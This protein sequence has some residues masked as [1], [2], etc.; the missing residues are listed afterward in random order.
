MTVQVKYLTEEEIEADANALLAEYSQARVMAL[1]PP[2]PVDD[3]LETQLGLS[4]DF[5]DIQTVLGVP[6]VLGAMWVDRREVFIDQSLDPDRFP[7]VEGRFHFSVAHEIGHWR[8]HRHYFKTDNGQRSLSESSNRRSVV[9]RTSQAKERIEWQADYYASCLLMPKSMVLAAWKNRFGNLFN[10]PDPIVYEDVRK[11][12]LVPIEDLS[13]I[14]AE[15]AE[16]I[17]NVA[18]EF[19]PIFRVSVQAM[20]IRLEKLGL[21]VVERPL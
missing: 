16:L 2:V 13:E 1:M 9:C 21:L 11:S 6:D 7:E 8:K 10:S 4:L 5:D 20:R 19:T 15:Q 14:E 12:C 18:K 17:D 3:I